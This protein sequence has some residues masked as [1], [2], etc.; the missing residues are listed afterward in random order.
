MSF[1]ASERTETVMHACAIVPVQMQHATNYSCI[2]LALHCVDPIHRDK[3][4]HGISSV[5]TDGFVTYDLYILI[6]YKKDGCIYLS[7][8]N[9][10]GCTVYMCPSSRLRVYLW[11][12]CKLQ[13]Y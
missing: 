9:S 6:I 10:I 8:V 1:D 2:W 12:A 5:A 4:K 13:R 3:K 11:L 7:D